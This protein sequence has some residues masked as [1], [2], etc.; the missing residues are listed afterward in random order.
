MSSIGCWALNGKRGSLRK[1]WLSPWFLEPWATPAPVA[2]VGQPARARKTP[3]LPKRRRCS[4]RPCK[5][6]AC[7]KHALRAVRRLRRQ[8]KA[9]RRWAAEASLRAGAA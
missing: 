2:A 3:G 4:P 5:D 8:Q 6:A 1:D 9:L 7:R